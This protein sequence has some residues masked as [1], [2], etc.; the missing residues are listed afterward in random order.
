MLVHRCQ[1]TQAMIYIVTSEN[2][3]LFR[4]DLFQMHR[5]RRAVFVDRLRWQLPATGLGEID[6]YDRRDTIYLIARARPDEPIQASARLLPTD[7]P[8]LMGDLFAHACSS[9]PPCGRS[10]WEAS[11]F[12]PAPELSRRARLRSLGE[13]LCGILETCLLFGTEQIVFTANSALLPLT[14]HC[15]WQASVLGPTLPDG[16]D[17]ITAVQVQVHFDGLLAL[18]RRFGIHAPIARYL[19]PQ[20]A[21][22]A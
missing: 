14:L 8:H 1:G 10:I 7:R 18:R 13:I 19:L 5:H 6:A 21:R 15:G 2:R 22:A 20:H 16:D 12:C 17:Q 3:D 11:R 4:Q 9:P